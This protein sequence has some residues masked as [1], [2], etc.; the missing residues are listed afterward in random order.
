MNSHEE[1][2]PGQANMGGTKSKWKSFL[3]P[4][5]Q[6]DAAL[7]PMQVRVLTALEGIARYKAHVF[8]GDDYIAL[9]TPCSRRGAQLALN[10]LVDAGYVRRGYKRGRSDVPGEPKGPGRVLILTWKD[11]ADQAI[12][13]FCGESHSPDEVGARAQNLRSPGD[14]R[15]QDLRFESAKTAPKPSAKVAHEVLENSS[16]VDEGKKTL[17][18]AIGFSSS[19][20]KTEDRQSSPASE[21]AKPATEERPAPPEPLSLLEE[22]QALGPQTDEGTKEQLAFW[23]AEDLRDEAKFQATYKSWI[24]DVASGKEPHGRLLEAYRAG[25]EA[26]ADP[27]VERPGSIAVNR[28][29][30]WKPR[31]PDAQVSKEVH[32]AT[33]AAPTPREPEPEVFVSK[34][35]R[36]QNPTPM[37]I[38]PRN[39]GEIIL[40]LSASTEPRIIDHC[41]SLM[42]N[43]L[44]GLNNL[45]LFRR[46][47]QDAVEGKVSPE[48]V[49]DAYQ[50]ACRVPRNPGSDQTAVFIDS[51]ERRAAEERG[52]VSNAQPAKELALA[53]SDT[54]PAAPDVDQAERDKIYKRQLSELLA[55]STNKLQQK[56]KSL[57]NQLCEQL[58]QETWTS[59]EPIS[60][61]TARVPAPC[62]ISMGWPQAWTAEQ[63]PKSA[64]LPSLPSL[65]SIGQPA[66]LI[67]GNV[68]DADEALRK[69]KN[70]SVN[71]SAAL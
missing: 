24:D 45:H 19:D 58:V 61:L 13:R 66:E 47:L 67:E 49:H 15:A 70:W 21:I 39:A 42:A 4:D 1:A 57:H 40:S 25:R 29:K 54:T 62:L 43:R 44:G 60:N 33:I 16:E 30:I 64:A 34:R 10:A 68:V 56:L 2:T 27:L 59:P 69:F 63:T 65:G 35:R 5:I 8:A 26:A 6:E 50:D 46:A 17:R 55:L 23:I 31:K 52:T 53:A 71:R 18:N 12:R 37:E 7:T 48:R 20:S 32:S 14:G 11:G 28:W 22:I 9:K 41:A 38:V 36:G 3:P 51:L